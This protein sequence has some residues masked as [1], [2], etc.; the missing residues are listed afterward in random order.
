MRGRDNITK[1]NAHKY[2]QNFYPSREVAVLQTL[3]PYLSCQI[4]II[5][6]L[7]LHLLCCLVQ[8][9]MGSSLYRSQLAHFPSASPICR[10]A[11]ISADLS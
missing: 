9:L 4:I 5:G 11:A 8:N 7:H 2:C 10:V 3:H 1:K 6:G